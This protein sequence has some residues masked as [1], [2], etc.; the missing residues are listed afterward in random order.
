MIGR[1]FG[2]VADAL[3]AVGGLTG[4]TYNEVNVLMYYLV[5]PLSWGVML[6]VWLRKPIFGPTVIVVW[7]GI[8]IAV[9]SHFSSWCDRVFD[10]SVDFL[11]WFNQFGG[12]YILNSV[13]ICVVL[14]LA[15]YGLLTWLLSK[16]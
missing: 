11:N 16:G 6:D 10:A 15:I 9:R 2:A 5:V 13:I 14:P 7:I 4:L 8:F 1:I 12:N 3:V